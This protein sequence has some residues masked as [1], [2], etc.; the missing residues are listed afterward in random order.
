[1][2]KLTMIRLC[3]S[4]AWLR[5]ILLKSFE[6][7]IFTFQNNAGM[8]RLFLLTLS[9]IFS[10]TVIGQPVPSVRE[11]HYM[12]VGTYDSPKSEGVYVYKFN[13]NDG[14]AKEIS[15]IKTPNASFVA[16]SPNEK[17]IYAVNEDAP[18]D[19]K[20]GEIVAFTFNKENGSLSLIN[21]Q[22]SGGD[23]PCHVEVDKTG[24]WVFASN[25][26]SGSLSVFPVNA[27]GGL[28]AATTIQHYGAGKNEQRQKGPHV[29]GAIISADNRWL[30]VTDLGIDKVMIY[31]F[32][33]ATGKL[34]PASQP[35][36]QS[37]AGSGPRLFTFHPNKKF[38]YMIEELS[39][40]I[41]TYKYKKG[42][43]KTIQRI[44]TMPQ[45][46]TQFAG[47]ADIHVST[48]GK[49]LYASNRGDV[50]T[51]A[52]YTI[53]ENRGTLSLIKI[54]STLG[55]AP[56]NFSIDPSGKF[57]L[58]ENQNSDEIVIF[59][60]DATTGLLTDSGNRVNIGK[61]V[62]IKWISIN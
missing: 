59:K 37:E 38:A 5:H 29:H 41:V 10:L 48:D 2:V 28:G 20:G 26:S 36:A 46:S 9:F 22:P 31:A 49:F 33:A 53:N 12:I 44:S 4:T 47:S 60:R 32:D 43:L 1:M 57:L 35:F 40:T 58:A 24:K 3:Q 14:T 54:Q 62:C 7:Q 56:R 45:H 17:F 39:G 21:K 52:I 34:T 27:D 25:Y 30:F 11:E 8:K 6:N 50:N 23:H 18:K 16:V 51:I 13:G 15:H 55:K 19:G 42:K 61:P